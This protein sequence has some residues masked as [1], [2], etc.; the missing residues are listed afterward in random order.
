MIAH[1]EHIF[2]DSTVTDRRIP[3]HVQEAY[4]GQD[5]VEVDGFDEI[6]KYID[7]KD[8]KSIINSGKKLLY[9]NNYK[10][11][12]VKYC[13]ATS[14]G[15]YLCCDLHTIN[16]M[17]NCVYNCAYCILQ[18]CLTNPVMQVHCNLDYVFDELDQFD[19]K[20]N[21]TM[22]ICTGEVA[23][24]LA[25]DNILQQNRYLVEYF[26]KSKNLYLELKTKS[27]AVENLLSLDSKGR[28]IVSFS[29]NPANVVNKIEL[30]TASLDNRLKAARKLLDHGYHV[31]LNI[32][33]VLYYEGWQDDY[34]ELFTCLK[35]SFKPG[36]LAWLHV[37]LLRYIPGLAGIVRQRFPGIKIFDQEFVQGPDNKYRYPKPLRDEMYSFLY[38]HIDD[39]DGSIPLYSCVEQPS[40]WR[41]FRP[42]VPQNSHE[43]NT[44]VLER[45][46]R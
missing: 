25:L 32:D 11:E 29:L 3:K 7:R 30:H 22:R 15:D 38:K 35:M 27:D 9:L 24:S 2:I 5:L 45:L 34:I 26:S 21:Q 10:G 40:H 20:I 39:W 6:K 37:G 42:Q 18:A 12:V 33:P 23:D 41:K 44:K 36:E 14:K 46:N 43:I 1:F 28:T 4:P 16:L 17:S 31:A 13:P 8:S 19:K